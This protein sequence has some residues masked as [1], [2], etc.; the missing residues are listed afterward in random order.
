MTDGEFLGG[1]VRCTINRSDKSYQR[2]NKGQSMVM[3]GTLVGEELGVRFDDCYFPWIEVSVFLAIIYLY[4]KSYVYAGTVAL[5][6]ECTTGDFPSLLCAAEGY[7]LKL[8]MIVVLIMQNRWLNFSQGN[9]QGSMQPAAM[10]FR[11]VSNQ[12]LFISGGHMARTALGKFCLIVIWYWSLSR[13]AFWSPCLQG[14]S[15]CC[16]IWSSVSISACFPLL[17]SAGR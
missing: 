7:Q 11:P 3:I 13:Q 9:N 12:V 14:I 6:G 2:F 15:Y 16:Q 1:S 10:A 5:W 4:A 8:P 17:A